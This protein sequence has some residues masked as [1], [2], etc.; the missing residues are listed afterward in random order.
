MTV[1]PR[2]L[3]A[4]FRPWV[5][6]SA[7]APLAC[8]PAER[9]SA[10]SAYPPPSPQSAQPAR[11]IVTPDPISLGTLRPGQSAEVAVTV[12]NPGDEDVTLARVEPSCD[13]VRIRPMPIRV[14]AGRSVALTVSFDPRTIRTSGADW[15]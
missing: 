12:R 10:S 13:C 8:V 5:L 9:E 14:Q 4:T 15:T 3:R 7:L 11:L 6:L 2:F 1:R